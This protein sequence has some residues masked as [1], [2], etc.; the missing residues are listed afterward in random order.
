MLLNILL[1]PVTVRCY[2]AV[3]SSKDAVDKIPL[4]PNSIGPEEC[5]AVGSVSYMLH[6]L[7]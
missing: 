3:R 6:Q 7:Y 5:R 4:V 1:K 2:A